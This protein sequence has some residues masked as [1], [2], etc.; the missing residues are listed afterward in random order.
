MFKKIKSL[1]F[2]ELKK[3]WV[4]CQQLIGDLK[5]MQNY[6][7]FSPLNTQP[8][9]LSVK[10]GMFGCYLSWIIIPHFPDCFDNL[11]LMWLKALPSNLSFD[12]PSSFILTYFFFRWNNGMMPWQSLENCSVLSSILMTS[13]CGKKFCLPNHILWCK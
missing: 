1:H 11:S 8:S 10:K 7:N 12:T 6:L 13:R 3:E 5:H 4:T 2:L 9:F